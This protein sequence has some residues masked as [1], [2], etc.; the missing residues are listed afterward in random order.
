MASSYGRY[1]PSSPSSNFYHVFFSFFVEDAAKRFVGSLFRDLQRRGFLCFKSNEKLDT[2]K[3]IPLEAIQCSRF[4]VVII[5]QDYISSNRC[6]DELVEIIHCRESNGQSVLP[7]FYNVDS[8]QIKEQLGS[9]MVQKWGEALTEVSLIDGWNFRDWPDEQKLIEEVANVITREWSHMPLGEFNGLIGID[10]RIEQILSL[11]DMESSG[12]LFLGIWGMGGIGKTTIAKA[13]FNHISSNFEAAC[14]VNVS[15]EL[16]KLSITRLREQ[17]LSKILEEKRLN[18]GMH[19]VLPRHIMNRLRRKKILVVLDTV[20]DVEQSATLT[21]DPS[22]FGP[23]SRIIITCRD[24]QVLMHNA[25]EIYEV[26]GLNYHES[27]QLLSLKAFKQNHPIGDYVKLSQRVVNYTKGVPLALNVLGS[28]LCN[29]QEQEWESTLEKLEESPNLEVQKVLKVSYDGLEQLDKDIFL[30]IACFF[31]GGDVDSVIGILDGCDFFPSSGISRLVDKS[32]LEITDNKLDMHDLLREMGQD[33]VR[34][35]S[36]GKP[37]GCSRLWDPEDVYHVLTSNKGSIATEGIFLDIS[38]SEK[39]NFSPAAFS[40]MCNLRLLKFYQNSTLSWKNPSG[41]ISESMTESR[42]GLQSLPTKLCYFHWHGYPW[43]C[44]PSDFFM[45]NLVELNMPFSQVKELWHGIKHLRKLKQIDLHDSENLIRLPDLSSAL[46]LERIV[47]DNCTSL[48]EIHSSVQCL[49][50]LS[51][52]SLSN[53]KELQS[54]PSLVCLESLQTLKLSSCANLKEFPEVSGHIEELHLDGTRLEEWPSSIRFLDSLR[55]LSLDHCECL[56]TLPSSIHLN[57]LDTLDLSWCSSLEKF[58]EVKGNIKHLNL[59]YTGIEKLPSSIGSLSSLVKLNL[60]G[61][62]IEELPLSIGN[63]TSLVELNLKESSITE[64]PS[65]IG[66]LTSLVKLN[67]SVSGIE[68]LPSSIG[69]LSSLV[70]FNLEKSSLTALPSSIGYLTSLVKLNLAVTEVKEL[71]PSIGN[72]S[73]LVELN[74]SQCPRLASLP[75]SIGELKCLEKLYLCGLRRLKSLPRSIHQLKRLKDLYLNHCKNL[76][77]LPPLSGFGSLRDLV[78][79]YTGIIKIPSTLGHLSSLQVL[80][81]KSNNF[82][83]I[84]ACINQLFSLEVLDISYCKRLKSL[85]E[86]PPRIRVVLAYNCTSLR[87]VSSPFIQLQES[88]EQPPLEKSGFTFANCVSLE[89]D[90]CGYILESTFLKFQCLATA[91]QELPTRD[92]DILVSPVVCFPGSEVPECFR[93]QSNGSSI[94]TLLPPH[95]YDT[96]LV[97]FTFCAVIELENLYYCDGFTFECNFCLEN[98]YGDSLE[99]CSRESG[100]WGNQFA[101]ESDHVFFWNTSCV[102][103]LTEQ[104]YERLKENSCR[105][106]FEYEVYLEDE[107]KVMLPAGSSKFKVKSCG[108]NPVYTKDEKE[109]NSWIDQPSSSYDSMVV[110][111]KDAARSFGE[112]VME[113]NSNKKRSNKYKSDRDEAEEEKE[114]PQHKKLK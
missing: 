10:S 24:K 92:E 93:Y 9:E 74:L 71:P 62:A 65:S 57:S 54:L 33:I 108:F 56:K 4:S 11:L 112:Q 79:S 46:N 48:L 69:Q 90:A 13:L 111:L 58:P 63:L 97:G 7:I 82:M 103:V 8:Y 27:L 55:I 39:V 110:C 105:A 45:E 44:L 15:E 43:E 107:F 72:L 99:F 83:R 28:F 84:P 76:S 3:P 75:S 114:K 29:K 66:S 53:C 38:K 87:T 34:G 31:R 95:W 2:E 32:L 61:T 41:F 85:P 60:K 88:T 100:E 21:G 59:K 22:W 86:L 52:L 101:F 36:N 102:D 18:L 68:E 70:E 81:L 47:L 20:S 30:D 104:R 94:G 35:E 80:L 51:Y 1:I 67:L 17:I 109:T 113:I 77:K 23:G 98:E 14:F 19:S 89:K 6:L 49:H 26:K 91:L 12:V 5:S 78:L 96:K 25:G 106:T 50:R 42:D 73:S 64:L 37:G 40:P 16:E